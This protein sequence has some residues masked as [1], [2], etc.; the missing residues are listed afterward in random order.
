M[1]A[2][3]SAGRP[4][5]FGQ[6]RTLAVV[7]KLVPA[8]QLKP[9][10]EKEWQLVDPQTLP[11][12]TGPAEILLH[13]LTLLRKDSDTNRRLAMISVDNAVEL[14]VKTFL[15][16]P[17]RLSGLNITRREYAD[18]SESFPAL[19]DALERHA[20]DKLTGIDLG[21]IEWYHRLRNQL[22]HQGNG[23][24]V[25]RDKIEIYAEVANIL[26]LNLFGS[27]LVER[28]SEEPD[29]LGPFIEAWVKLERGLAA[30][31]KRE[32]ER[33]AL[34][35]PEP[36]NVRQAAALLRE[37]NLFSETDITAINN[38]R[39]IRNDVLHTSADH[40]MV[41]T[42]NIVDQLREFI[43]RIPPE[44]LFYAKPYTEAQ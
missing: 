32:I 5:E 18:F 30:L 25:E 29:L 12:A 14:M 7:S 8:T 4:A 34:Q 17:K 6:K 19:L 26:L 37:T 24:T 22:Y 21:T 35:S 42:Q 27:R 40:R 15:G 1:L 28:V 33:M 2:I 16:L 3:W 23:L 10:R 13:G 20:P 44:M 41:I 9:M 43:A 31:S 36:R 11:W 38:F 39:R